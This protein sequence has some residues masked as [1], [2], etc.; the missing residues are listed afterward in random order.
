[1]GGLLGS[2]SRGVRLP[3]LAAW[4]TRAVT[5]SPADRALEHTPLRPLSF[6]HRCAGGAPARRGPLA[7]WASPDRPADPFPCGCSAPILSGDIPLARPKLGRPRPSRTPSKASKPFRHRR[8]WNTNGDAGS[9]NAMRTGIKESSPSQT[10]VWSQ[11][12]RRLP[13][14]VRSAL[15]P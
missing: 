5:G 8:R 7:A 11:R 15:L 14:L 6:L 9:V 1:V 13:F 3:A 10:V 12:C 4:L 2:A